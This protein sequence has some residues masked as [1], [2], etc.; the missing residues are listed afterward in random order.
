MDVFSSSLSGFTRDTISYTGQV[1]STYAAHCEGCFDQASASGVYTSNEAAAA[2][3]V[4]KMRLPGWCTLLFVSLIVALCVA[5]ELHDIQMCALPRRKT[6]IDSHESAL[7]WLACG[8]VGSGGIAPLRAS[9]S[10]SF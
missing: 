7:H 6:V 3:S 8:A 1:A 2:Y 10:S 9:A 5:N 4:S